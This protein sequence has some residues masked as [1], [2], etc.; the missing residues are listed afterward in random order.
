MKKFLLL[1]HYA[2]KP[3]FAYPEHDCPLAHRETAHQRI[4]DFERFWDEGVLWRTIEVENTSLKALTEIINED[5]D[6]VWLSGS[7]YLL[8]EADDQPWIKN[9]VKTAEALLQK[10]FPVVGLCFGLQLLAKAAGADVQLTDKFLSGETD[11]YSPTGEFLV[12]TKTYHENYV[13]N[14]P[15]NSK[16]LGTTKHNHPYIV[17]FAHKIY[18]IQSHPECTLSDDTKKD[19]ADIFW[20]DFFKKIVS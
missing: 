12:T 17:Q 16:V 6:A 1:S 3:G 2:P 19:A 5:W 15:A 4:Y 14:L 11:I 13:T 9:A 20:K 8:S 7:P 18:G 10:S